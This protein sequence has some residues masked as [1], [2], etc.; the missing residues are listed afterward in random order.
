MGSGPQ[1]VVWEMRELMLLRDVHLR[2]QWR[3]AEL[4]M[5]MEDLAVAAGYNYVSFRS[6]LN[7]ISRI[8]VAA[9]LRINRAL[10]WGEDLSHWLEPVQWP[11]TVIRESEMKLRFPL[12]RRKLKGRI[13]GKSS[14][15]I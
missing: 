6:L 5:S 14:D 13:R 3:A 1:T 11:A 12:N 10:Q 2:M 4:G 9:L 8:N 7:R 15:E